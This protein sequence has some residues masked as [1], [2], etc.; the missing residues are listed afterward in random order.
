MEN[1]QNKQPIL[2]LNDLYASNVIYTSRPS[3]GSNPWLE[4]EEH[5][6]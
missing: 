3:Y 5:Q 4:L 6:S 1:L 2:T